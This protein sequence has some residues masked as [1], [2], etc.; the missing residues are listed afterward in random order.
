[1]AE[2]DRIRDIFGSESEDDDDHHL[3]EKPAI[4][5]STEQNDFG[6][7]DDEADVQPAR[8]RQPT[9]R[10]SPSPSSPG[11]SPARPMFVKVPLHD[12]LDPK[13]LRLAKLSNILGLEPKPFDPSTF[14]LDEDHHSS[15]ATIRW[16]WASDAQGNL[17][18]EGNARIVRWSDGSAQLFLGEDVLELKEI[19]ISDDNNYIFSRHSNLMQGMGQLLQ[20]TVFHPTGLASSFHQRLKGQVQKHNLPKSRVKAT[21]TLVDPNKLNLEREQAEEQRIRDKERLLDRQQKAMR[22]YGPGGGGALGRAAPRGGLS[23]AFLEEADY[24]DEDEYGVNG[25]GGGGGRRGPMGEEEEA[26]AERRLREAKAVA[27]LPRSGA[28]LEDEDEDEDE[29]EMRDFIV[30]DEDEEEKQKGRK[31][32]VG[33]EDDEESSGEEDGGEKK[34]EEKEEEDGKPAAKRQRGAVIID[35]D[36]D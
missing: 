23:T 19:D 33:D 13:E 4:P 14:Q 32:T 27:S 3:D 9:P 6:D 29:D 8:Q 21:T 10:E 2:D 31:R 11:P 36:S 28:A 15:Q 22:R 24:G 17:K 12:T 30:D 16:R 35:S 26:E 34:G 20:K 5:N 1:M 25:G 18:K 7:D